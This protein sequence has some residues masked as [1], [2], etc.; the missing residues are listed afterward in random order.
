VSRFAGCLRQRTKEPPQM[1]THL[2]D[3][4]RLDMHLVAHEEGMPV[5]SANRLI[6][7]QTL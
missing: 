5:V 7:P 2:A 6:A 4:H 3:M 1:K